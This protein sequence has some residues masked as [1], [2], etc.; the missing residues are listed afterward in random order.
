MSKEIEIILSRKSFEE[1]KRLEKQIDLENREP[2]SYEQY[3]E[4]CKKNPIKAR[5]G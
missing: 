4:K 3:L 2:E 1:L 5:F